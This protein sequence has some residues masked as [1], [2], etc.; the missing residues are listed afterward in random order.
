VIDLS[1]EYKARIVD[2]MFREY[3]AG[4]TPNPDVLCNREIKFDVFLKAAI[5]LGADYVATGHYV[6]K[7]TVETDL[8]IEHQLLQGLD[9]NKDQSYFLCQLTQEQL[10]H[11]LFPIGDMLKNDVRALALKIG[12]PTAEKK[13]SQGLCFVGKV[14]LPV[15]LQQQLKENPGRIIEVGAD[16]AR[17]A[18]FR[19]LSHEEQILH[20]FRWEEH[21]GKMVGTHQGIQFYTVGQRK[22]L[23][24]GGKPLPLFVLQTDAL[25]NILYVGQGENHPGMYFNGL[26]IKEDDVHWLSQNYTLKK[27]NSLRVKMRIRYRQKLF[28]ATLSMQDQGLLV[29]FD[30][31]VKNVTP[32]QFAVFYADSLLFGSG[33]ISS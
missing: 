16:N 18:A 12:L 30:T 27:G 24:I 4:R 21:D 23:Q 26:M 14:K 33:V 6:R 2:Y 19:E 20:P 25:N 13:D 8:G 31:P 17:F 10:A 28:E 1:V 3:G 15:F 22:G 32:G 11:S 29:F 9:P 5:K 7:R